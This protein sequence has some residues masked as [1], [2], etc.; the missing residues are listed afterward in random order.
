MPIKNVG[1]DTPIS[2]TVVLDGLAQLFSAEPDC[3]IVAR[4]TN[5]EEAL[6]AVLQFPTRMTRSGV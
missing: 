6:H 5:G 2:D 3:K 4:A 1:S